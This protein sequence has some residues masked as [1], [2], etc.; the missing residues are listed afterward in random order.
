MMSHTTPPAVSAPVTAGHPEPGSAPPG[1]V[2]RL[3]QLNLLRVGYFVMGVGLAVVKWP[4][5]LRETSWGLAEGTVL[6]LLLAMS[7][8]ALLGL[9]HPQRMLP[10][11]LFEVAWKLAWLGVV[12]LPAWLNGTMDDATGAQVESVLWVAIVIAV[13]PWRQVVRQYVLA[14]G[15]PWRRRG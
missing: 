2:L 1:T 13:I 11:L 5:L 10:I 4:L 14:P 8:L 9:R 3:W 6:C 15:E 7:V 12:A